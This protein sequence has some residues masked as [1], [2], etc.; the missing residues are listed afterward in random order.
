MDRIRQSIGGGQRDAEQGGVV[1]EISTATSSLSFSTRLK[2]FGVCFAV[3]IFCSVLGTVLLWTN[4]KAF[5]VLYTIGNIS[6]ISG[7]CFL[8]GPMKQLK[9][10]FAEKRLIASVVMLV[11]LVLTLCAALWWDKKVLALLFVIIQFL[12]MS[13]YCISYM[14]IHQA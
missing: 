2:C 3:G 12:A 1:A 13:W 11:S 6:A 7:S 8:M 14:E 5:A 9:N 10:M 4:M